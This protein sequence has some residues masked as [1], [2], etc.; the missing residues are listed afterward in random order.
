MAQPSEAKPA[1]AK[2]EAGSPSSRRGRNS[3]GADSMGSSATSSRAGASARGAEKPK[4]RSTWGTSD[5]FESGSSWTREKARDEARFAALSSEMDGPAD[6]AS[7]VS[8]RRP[9]NPRPDGNSRFVVSRPESSLTVS[10][11]P[12]GAVVA[13]MTTAEG[14]GLGQ[15]I[16]KVP[17]RFYIQ[18]RDEY[19]LCIAA[20]LADVFRIHIVGLETPTHS[21]VEEDDGRIMVSWLPTVSG[22]FKVIVTINGTH[23]QDSPYKAVASQGHIAAH[24]CAV[25]AVPEAVGVGQTA[26]FDIEARDQMGNL[27]SYPPLSTKKYSFRVH[28]DGPSSAPAGDLLYPAP[29]PVVQLSPLSRGIQH[30]AIPLTHVGSYTVSVLGEDGTLV[31]GRTHAI[32]VEATAVHAKYC[33]CYGAGLTSAL[34][35]KGGEFDIRAT[36]KHGNACEVSDAYSATPDFGFEARLRFVADSASAP[37]GATNAALAKSHRVNRFADEDATESAGTLANLGLSKAQGEQISAYYWSYMNNVY[38]E[39]I[40]RGKFGEMTRCRWRSR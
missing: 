23:I 29:A 37:G 40:K 9:P 32:E 6:G 20:S 38:A 35:G 5:R 26:H 27:A 36:D 19:G 12:P 16:L 30:V 22:D 2:G 34:A 10:R 24:E 21:V 4:S 14:M 1:E 33:A 28:V 7:Q 25:V 17:G 13:R 18:P 8:S 39:L 3:P 11:S 31:G 15:S